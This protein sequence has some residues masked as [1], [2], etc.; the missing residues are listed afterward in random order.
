MKYQWRLQGA[1][2]CASRVVQS[3]NGTRGVI[4]QQQRSAHH[5]VGLETRTE[6]T[7]VEV[8]VNVSRPNHSVWRAEVV[9]AEGTVQ[10]ACKYT[11]N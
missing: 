9:R 2:T 1:G 10:N 11:C 7:E 5:A 8:A 4:S 3:R 6:R